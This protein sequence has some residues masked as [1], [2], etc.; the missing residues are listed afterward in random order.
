MRRASGGS[1]PP[2]RAAPRAWLRRADTRRRPRPAVAAV[3]RELS[4]DAPRGRLARLLDSAGWRP[5]NGATGTLRTCHTTTIRSLARRACDRPPRR[6]ASGFGATLS[7]PSPW[8][9]SSSASSS[10]ASPAGW[11]RSRWS[12][13]IAAGSV[14]LLPAIIVGYAVKA[15]D[16]EDREQGRL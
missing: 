4:L 10:S 7:S 5:V 14:V 15:A 2:T 1:T 16:R 6:R 13:A 3:Q 9:C 11:W 8:S 12:T